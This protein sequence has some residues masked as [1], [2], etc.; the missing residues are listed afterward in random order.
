[1]IDFSLIISS[2]IEGIFKTLPAL[3]AAF[4]AY[5]LWRQ[6]I[7]QDQSDNLIK[8]SFLLKHFCSTLEK[9]LLE[10]SR[11]STAV[12]IDIVNDNLSHILQ[13]RSLSLLLPGIID[14]YTLWQKQ[15]YVDLI[16][17]HTDIIERRALLV[18]CQ[19]ACD[20]V[21]S[22]LESKSPSELLRIRFNS[23]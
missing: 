14:I 4:Y 7:V 17:S 18:A 2:F 23:L 11:K 20:S 19:G 13:S 10:D 22:V 1:M 12:T 21:I 5:R 9:N 6:K 16:Y 8:A 15:V 3:L